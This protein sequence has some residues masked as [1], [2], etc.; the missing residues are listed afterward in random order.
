MRGYKGGMRGML[1][2]LARV[3]REQEEALKRIA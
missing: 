3:L 1:Q 2:E